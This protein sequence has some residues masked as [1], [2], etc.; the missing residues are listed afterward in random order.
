M[1]G[2]AT[3]L[4]YEHEPLGIHISCICPPEVATAMVLEECKEGNRISLDMKAAADTLDTDNACDQIVAGLDAGRWK[5][6]PG[7]NGKL[8]TWIAR[9]FPAFF[10]FVMLK[11]I[12]RSMRK[13]GVL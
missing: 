10:D 4:R 8:I 11:L 7:V 9:H 1:V 5:I 3:I 12:K 6:I 13:H 2:L